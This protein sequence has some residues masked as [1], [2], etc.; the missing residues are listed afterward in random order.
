MRARLQPLQV[1]PNHGP[2]RLPQLVS[3]AVNAFGGPTQPAE[4]PHASAS[5]TSPYDDARRAIDGENFISTFLTRAGPT[6]F[7]RIRRIGGRS[8]L[9]SC[10][11]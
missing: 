10:A 4:F 8:T 7:H 6:T 2:H 1:S 11:L 9:E 5:Y 3:Y